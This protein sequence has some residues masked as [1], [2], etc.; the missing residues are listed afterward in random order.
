MARINVVSLMLATFIVFIFI[1]KPTTA[2]PVDKMPES[3][4]VELMGANG[5]S[6]IAFLG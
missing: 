4:K 3:A 2:Q 5:K 1:S 6:S